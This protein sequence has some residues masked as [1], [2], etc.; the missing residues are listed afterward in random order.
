MPAVPNPRSAHE[1]A[2]EFG[3]SVEDLRGTDKTT[4]DKVKEARKAYAEAKSNG[5]LLDP[6][7]TGGSHE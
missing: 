7:L 6:P 2:S 3:V 1:I 4:D 5:T